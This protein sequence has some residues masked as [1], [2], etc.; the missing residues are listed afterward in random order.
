MC[1]FTISPLYLS[2]QVCRTCEVIAFL[3]SKNAMS[4]VSTWW[5]CGCCR[6]RRLRCWKQ[7]SG[8]WRIEHCQ[9]QKPRQF[10]RHPQHASASSWSHRGALWS[11]TP[12]PSSESV[13][14]GRKRANSGGERDKDGYEWNQHKLRYAVLY[15]TTCLRGKS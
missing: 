4:I 5:L 3:T 11:E 7:M 8:A 2:L 1:V 15:K 10:A 6:L 9:K 12:V 14:Q 13:Q